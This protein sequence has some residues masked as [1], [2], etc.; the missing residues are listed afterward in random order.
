MAGRCCREEPP[1]ASGTRR[2]ESA[3]DGW[4]LAAALTYGSDVSEPLFNP[5]HEL[6]F[7]TPAHKPHF[8][9]FPNVRVGSG[10][11]DQENVFSKSSPEQLKVESFFALR[12]VKPWNRLPMEAVKSPSLEETHSKPTVFPGHLLQVPLP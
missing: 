6:K 7:F 4:L 1:G 8:T 9:P 11:Y 5:C 3:G 12:V 10:V 2:M